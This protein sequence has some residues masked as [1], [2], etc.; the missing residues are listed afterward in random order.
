MTRNPS[1]PVT[2]DDL[3]L[4]DLPA[5]DLQLEDLIHAYRAGGLIGCARWCAGEARTDKLPM[6]PDT[7][8]A[9]LDMMIAA[10]DHVGSELLERF[11]RIAAGEGKH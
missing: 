7:V 11:A 9:C 5:R 4:A 6:T 8:E 2:A 3:A 10:F 1:R